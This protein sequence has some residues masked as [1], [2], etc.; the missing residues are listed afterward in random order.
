MLK[1]LTVT[2]L[3]ISILIE[4]LLMLIYNTRNEKETFSVMLKSYISK[5]RPRALA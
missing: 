5:A 2:T 1:G 3:L 4:L